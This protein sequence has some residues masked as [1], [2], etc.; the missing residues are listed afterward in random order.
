MDI[1]FVTMTSIRGFNVLRFQLLC[2][3]SPLS[4]GGLP[5]GRKVKGIIHWLEKSH[6]K[7]AKFNLYD[8]LFNEKNPDAGEKGFINQSSKSFFLKSEI[9]WLTL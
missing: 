3:S 8:R 2:T 1:K 9:P 7:K 4:P 5:E 6:A